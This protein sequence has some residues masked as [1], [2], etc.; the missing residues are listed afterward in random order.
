M[1]NTPGAPRRAEINSANPQLN[2]DSP[3]PLLP[4]CTAFRQ[5]GLYY[6]IWCY[7]I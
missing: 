2:V 7:T 5:I 1:G 6:T 3:C 4:A